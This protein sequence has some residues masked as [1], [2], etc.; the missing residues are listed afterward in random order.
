MPAWPELRGP[1][2]GG[3][4]HR[5]IKVGL[6]AK[7]SEAVD[8]SVRVPRWDDEPV[9]ALAHDLAAGQASVDVTISPVNDTAVEPVETVVLTLVPG[10]GYT[11]GTQIAI[12][13][14]CAASEFYH[15]GLYV[16]EGEGG[17][18]ALGRFRIE[19]LE[20]RGVQGRQIVGNPHKPAQVRLGLT[21]GGLGQAGGVFKE[22]PI[23]RRN[24]RIGFGEIEALGRG[25]NNQQDAAP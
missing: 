13:L 21:L 3:L 7:S 5:G 11:A 9:D 20:A 25:K 15:D 22:P 16:L 2:Q 6:A 24:G 12:G 17:L 19:G 18:N 23:R 1:D 8:Q 4:G 14:D 10:A